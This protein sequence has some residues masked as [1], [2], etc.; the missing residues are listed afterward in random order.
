MAS[1]TPQLHFVLFPFM[2]Q[3]HMIPMMDTAK[4]LMHHNAIVTVVTTPLHATR[5]TS[6]F[7]RYIGLG[8]QI[9][10]VQ[11]QFPCE[12]AEV[13]HGCESIDMLPSLATAWTFY[14][15]TSFLRQPV[16]KLFEELTPP[17]SCII[18]DMFLPYTIHISRKFNIPRISFAGVSCF[19]LLCLHNLIAY[20]IEGS[21][22]S[23]S[24]YFVLPGIPD[25]IE[26]TIAQT[27]ISMGGNWKPF[28]D[29]LFAAEIA[30][31]GLITN[32]FQEL[33]PSYVADYKKIKN[34][35]VWCLG[36]LSLS[37]KDHLD[38]A[39]RGNKASIDECHLKCWLDSQKP[40]TVIY[41]CLGSLC[42][43]APP[44][45]ME[46]GFALEA[47]K[48][49]FIWVIR[50]GS[51]SEGLEKL[52][53]EDGFEERSNGRSLLIRGWAPQ[54][55]ILS[56]PAIGGF[57]THCGWNSTLEAISAGVPMLTWPQFADQFYN[58]SLVVHILK[59]GVKVGVESPA[60]KWGEEVEIGVQ[61]KKEDIGRAV[62]RLMD[63][64]SGSEERRKRV[65][66][67]A[68][69]AN[70]TVEKGGSSHSNVTLL[71]QDIIQKINSQM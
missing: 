49:P 35:K 55:L 25:E 5:F 39:E 71:I 16:E 18:S 1:Q 40:K 69:M 58:E 41:A 60:V 51:K 62:E 7:D 42:N 37:N 14:E 63:D 36:P 21:I 4:I 64:T 46:L 70:K 19:F 53:K 29:E 12:K 57:I 52:I 47:S 68:E 45:L 33:E 59:V 11:L 28:N 48:R 56:H 54:L 22:T 65:K 13:P 6:F 9:R 8:F 3:G 31:Y 32:S 23:E 15:A 66:E 61:V 24:E 26:M 38:K 67:L 27:G 43:I 20:N 30:S 34:N 10:L 2:A 17:P 44:Q 50:E